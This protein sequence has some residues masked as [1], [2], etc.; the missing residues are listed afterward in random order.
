[1][2]RPELSIPDTD[3]ATVAEGAAAI[4]G[5]IAAS[6]GADQ[7][8]TLD[9]TVTDAGGSLS[10]DIS[11]EL[12]GTDQQATATVN[13]GI[14][15]LGA[16]T[17]S[18]AG[19]TDGAVTWSFTPADQVDNELAAGFT[20]DATLTD[21]DGDE[22]FD[23]HTI[24]VT[25]TGVTVNNPTDLVADEDDIVG[26]DGNPGGTNDVDPPSP[27]VGTVTYD[28]GDSPVDNIQLSTGATG[29][30]TL[31]DTPLNVVTIWQ[32]SDTGPGGVLVGYKEGGDAGSY[33]YD[34][35]G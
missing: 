23:T 6:E 14:Q 12:D 1:V 3:T 33:I 20:F 25:D 28:I 10:S 7:E 24:T 16:L 2:Q 8:G 30:V 11:F 13:N 26:A 18:Y 21:A 15:D 29:L 31:D 27:L 34:H 32:A 19:A 9:V 35:G 4:S 5:S 22:Q 17:I